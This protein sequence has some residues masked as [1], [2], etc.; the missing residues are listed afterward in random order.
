MSDTSPLDT[1]DAEP[2]EPLRGGAGDER[3]RPFPRDG[4][5]PADI[6]DVYQASRAD[7]RP[8]AD[9]DLAEC[10]HVQLNDL[11]EQLLEYHAR[12]EDPRLRAVLDSTAETLLVLAT[13][14]AEHARLH[15]S[16]EP[17]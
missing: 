1:P 13:T 11:A 10:A 14:V 15:A 7:P 5:T 8:V 17:W 4:R 9:Q 2:D 6:D 3:E 16:R 12:A